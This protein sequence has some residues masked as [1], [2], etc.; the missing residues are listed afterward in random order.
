ML[1]RQWFPRADSQIFGGRA[2]S[3]WPVVVMIMLSLLC[4][5]RVSS[6]G[7][8]GIRWRTMIYPLHRAAAMTSSSRQ[9]P[10]GWDD[11][12]GTACRWW[13]AVR[14]RRG[15]KASDAGPSPLVRGFGF[16]GQPRRLP[17]ICAPRSGGI[18]R[19]SSAPLEPTVARFIGIDDGVG[20]HVLADGEASSMSAISC[21]L[22][23]ALVTTFRSA[24]R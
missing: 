3:T 15:K 13:S 11:G 5:E 16:S 17:S 10:P 21:S 7:S 23:G 19:G 18:H 24:S 22:G 2:P 1:A 20:I 14:R 9:N 8:G 6:A 12:G 4:P